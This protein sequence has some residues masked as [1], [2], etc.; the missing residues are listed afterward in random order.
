MVDTE[1]ENVKENDRKK[2]EDET[3]SKDNEMESNM[4]VKNLNL[5]QDCQ[6]NNNESPVS[7]IAQKASLLKISEDPIV[8]STTT[9]QK[10]HDHLTIETPVE[11]RT[12]SPENEEND[13]K[14][15]ASAEGELSDDEQNLEELEE[16]EEYEV[17]P[18]DSWQ[19]DN[20]GHGVIPVD[21]PDPNFFAVKSSHLEPL[22]DIAE[23]AEESQEEC[24]D[25]KNPP[26]PTEENY[27]D[28]VKYGLCAKALYDYEAGIIQF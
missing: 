18:P 21:Q 15:Q 3:K 13:L 2:T 6:K 17:N 4:N 14:P 10:D 26:K 25:D 11:Q 7:N 27:V 24:E 12:P 28:K 8:V 22:E 16:E 1:K 23:E 5:N 19:P 20:R 9:I